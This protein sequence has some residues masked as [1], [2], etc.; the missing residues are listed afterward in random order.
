MIMIDDKIVSRQIFSECFLCHYKK[1][2]GACCIEGESGAPLKDEELSIIEELL[3]HIWSLLTDE[4]KS[5][6]EKQGT[7]YIDEAGEIVTSLVNGGQC[8]FATFDVDHNCLC[9]F[10]KLYREGKTDFPKPISCHLYPIRLHQYAH[11]VALNY[12]EWD[13]CRYAKVLGRRRGIPI[14]QAL[15]EPLVRAFGESF[16]QELEAC[17]KLLKSEG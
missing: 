15:R 2:R 16:Y 6:I 8:V 5:V 3:P 14:Y 7:S 13:I 9:A 17:D 4:A 12:D 10:E 11:A 1:C